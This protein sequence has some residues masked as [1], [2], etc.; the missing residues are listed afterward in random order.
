MGNG[1]NTSGKT[2]WFY[3][4]AIG[5]AFPILL[6]FMRVILIKLPFQGGG[7][8]SIFTFSETFKE[9]Y[10]E[11]GVN[12][13]GDLALLYICGIIIAVSALS[14]VVFYLRMF[15]GQEAAILADTNTAVTMWVMLIGSS[16]FWWMINYTNNM[17][18]K[19]NFGSGLDEIIG[20]Y[21]GDI[22]RVN[23]WI[24]L[25]IVVSI[26][27]LVARFLCLKE[28]TRIQTVYEGETDLITKVEGASMTKEAL[29]CPNCGAKC[30]DGLFCINCG[31]KLTE[32]KIEKVCKVCGAK[33]KEGRFCKKC[34]AEHSSEG[35]QEC[36]NDNPKTE[37]KH[38]ELVNE[39]IDKEE[40]TKVHEAAEE[41][42]PYSQ[43]IYAGLVRSKNPYEAETY[44]TRAAE[45]GNVKAMCEL[46]LGYSEH[47]NL[48]TKT[49]FGFYPK[50][51]LYWTTKAAENGD[52]D[53]MLKLALAYGTGEMLQ[54]DEAEE[55]RW[56]QKA[57]DAGSAEAHYRLSMLPMYQYNRK[58]RIELLRKAAE[59][60]KKSKDRNTFGQAAF[61]LGL[62]YLP[63]QNDEEMTRQAVYFFY[64]AFFS[65]NDEAL[66]E[67]K[68]LSYSATTEELEKWKKD[69]DNFEIR[70]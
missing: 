43:Y 47:H 42:D 70:M 37:N 64:L 25:A 68:E 65:G 27:C 50:K 23:E 26:V 30:L 13:T 4:I 29:I 41:G 57:A 8:Y 54:K 34:G 60:S 31:S 40:F 6:I 12:Y 1:S 18:R 17:L 35:T 59:V 56:L 28:A 66:Q 10:D 2:L 52:A 67:T 5:Q 62:E 39:A 9:V 7:E 32:Q 51:E 49:G 36:I 38:S 55:A 33:Y 24:P 46:A 15:S 19:E 63:K 45:Q 3:L 44:Y 14:A 20:N 69:A 61:E 11:S 16:L 48:N 22:I 53:S 21:Y 58:M